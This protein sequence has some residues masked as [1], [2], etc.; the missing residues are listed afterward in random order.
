M[1][2]TGL[3]V[4]GTDPT[5]GLYSR[6]GE[7]AEWVPAVW[8]EAVRWPEYAALC[9]D[10]AIYAAGDTVVHSPYMMHA[11]TNNADPQ[12]RIRLSTDIRHQLAR[13]A[14]APPGTTTTQTTTTCDTKSG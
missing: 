12:G 10:P 8:A 13:D 2:E 11:A 1:A 5:D 7:D 3:L 6:G 14:A 9:A 4:P